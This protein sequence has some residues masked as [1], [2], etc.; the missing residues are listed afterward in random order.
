MQ[1]EHVDIGLIVN[2]VLDRVTQQSEEK[3]NNILLILQDKD[4]RIA[5][6]TSEVNT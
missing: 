5:A 1:S 2:T 3:D 4:S 6:L